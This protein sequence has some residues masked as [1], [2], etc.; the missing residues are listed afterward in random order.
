MNHKPFIRKFG[1][2]AFALF[3][4]AATNVTAQK[5]G[6]MNS[7]FV[8]ADMPKTKSAKTSM[9][10]YSK[11]LN[12]DFTAKETKLQKKV[13]EAEKKYSEGNMNQNELEAIRADIQKQGAALEETRQKFQTQL[14][15]KEESLMQ[16]LIDEFTNAIKTAA[17]E[18]GYS[19][20]I[21]SSALLYADDSADVTDLVKAKLGM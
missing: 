3:C 14:L 4:F 5:I 8:F 17:Q 10:D 16:P 11:N 21:D 20:I 13:Q 15:E 7:Q 19:F 18:N 6:H 9:E 2:L 12:S 1:V